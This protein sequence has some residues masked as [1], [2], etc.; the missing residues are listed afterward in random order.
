MVLIVE[1]PYMCDCQK[2]FD[3]I[4][5]CCLFFFHY[6]RSLYTSVSDT[7]P[8]P[9]ICTSIRT[10]SVLAPSRRIM[11]AR[12]E[13]FTEPTSV[14]LMDR[15]KLTFS[16]FKLFHHIKGFLRKYCGLWRFLI[17]TRAAVFRSIGEKKRFNHN[18]LK[19]FF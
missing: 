13:F 8:P 3:N 14:G 2:P 9:N 10:P 4:V 6:S 18:K 7:S 11:P 15:F 19:I 16:T 17:P 1:L 5:F 12:L